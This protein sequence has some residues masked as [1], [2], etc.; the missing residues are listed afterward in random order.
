MQ[1]NLRVVLML[2]RHPICQKMKTNIIYHVV[3][4]LKQICVLNPLNSAFV[5]WKKKLNKWLIR[6]I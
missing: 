1:W 3:T 2:Q 4:P 5:I 6:G